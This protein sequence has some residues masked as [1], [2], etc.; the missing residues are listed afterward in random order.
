MRHD[1]VLASLLAGMAVAV[2]P[3]VL[4]FYLAAGPLVWLATGAAVAA[5]G[6]GV[7]YT[8]DEREDGADGAN[9]DTDGADGDADGPAPP[10]VNCP[11]CGA[12]AVAD[13]SGCEYC[14]A[15]LAE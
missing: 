2:L 9:G 11:E 14:G 6:M 4:A 13:G 15:A 1:L 12:R 3:G 5:V 10:T 7:A 8:A